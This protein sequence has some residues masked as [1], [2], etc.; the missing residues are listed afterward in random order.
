MSANDTIF[1]A[2][3]VIFIGII[4]KHIFTDIEP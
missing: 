2:V 1:L 3:G 4:L